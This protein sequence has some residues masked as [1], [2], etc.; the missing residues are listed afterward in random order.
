VA[1]RSKAWVCGRSLAGI[2]SSNP[3]GGMDVFFVSA[4]SCQVKVSERS[5]VQRSPTKCG[6]SECDREASTV[7]P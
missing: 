1:V 4:V 7:R 2:A 6:V 3:A 5:F